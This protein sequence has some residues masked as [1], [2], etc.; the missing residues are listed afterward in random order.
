MGNKTVKIE[1]IN[2]WDQCLERTNKKKQA[3]KSLIC[4]GVAYT[5]TMQ[6][7]AADMLLQHS[8]LQY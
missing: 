1:G 5:S 6:M 4:K 8:T 7:K 2:D 3:C